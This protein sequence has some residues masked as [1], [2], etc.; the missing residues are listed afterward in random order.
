LRPAA[1]RSFAEAAPPIDVPRAVRVGASERSGIFFDGLVEP[2][3]PFAGA[4]TGDVASASRAISSAQS[5]MEQR[6]AAQRRLRRLGETV[7]LQRLGRIE[8]IGQRAAPRAGA[9][10]LFTGGAGAL[11][12][13]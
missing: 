11:L 13:G 10:P 2:G 5:A 3:L 12:V 6:R 9:E 4:P 7:A 8:I 1:E